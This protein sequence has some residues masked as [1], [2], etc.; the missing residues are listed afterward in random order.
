MAHVAALGH[1]CSVLLFLFFCSESIRAPTTLGLS[2][3]FDLPTSIPSAV[4]SSA[5]WSSG[6][7]ELFEMQMQMQLGGGQGTL[8]S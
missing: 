8:W 7:N 2:L 4:R 3:D 5:A 6:A 1:A